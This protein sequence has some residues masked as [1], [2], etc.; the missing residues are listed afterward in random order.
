MV[1]P[2]TSNGVVK[3]R[4]PGPAAPAKS[5]AGRRSGIP[6]ADISDRATEADGGDTTVSSPEMAAAAAAEK[7]RGILSMF[8]RKKD[9]KETKLDTAKESRPTAAAAAVV[10]SPLRHRRHYLPTVILIIGRAALSIWPYALHY[11]GA[12][13]PLLID[14]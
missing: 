9:A 13:I 2:E 8:R 12:P 14:G 3:T 4:S 11:A 5:D 6:P 7:K 1:G 10:I